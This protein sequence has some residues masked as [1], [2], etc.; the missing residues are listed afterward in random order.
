MTIRVGELVSQLRDKSRAVTVRLGDVELIAEGDGAGVLRVGDMH[1]PWGDRTAQLFTGFVHGPQY[2]YVLREPLSWQRQIVKHHIDARADNEAIWYIEGN[3]VAGIYQPDAKVLPLVSVA[4][5]I[6][7][8]FD[9]N[10]TA[11]VLYSPDQVEINVI[12]QVKTVT[13]PGIEG[14]AGRPLEGTVDFQPRKMKVGDLS[15]GGVR[16]IIQPGKPERGPDIEELWFRC[17]CENQ[18]TRR[19]AG[20][21]VALRGRTVDEIL[22]EMNN[23][24]RAVWEGLEESGRAILHSASEPIPGSV[25]DFIRVV[26]S[27]RRINPATVLRLQERAAALPP[28]PSVYDVTQLITAMANEDGLPVKTRRNLEAIGGDLTIDTARMIHRCTQCERPLVAA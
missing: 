2:K 21:K 7:D 10:D 1:L 11:N 22:T 16:V 25:S 23:V 5:Q 19:I 9:P 26:S 13:V 14:V 15:A 6:A 27:E 17:F 24:M 18:M 20:S 28:N 4:E 8:V 3:S 12:S